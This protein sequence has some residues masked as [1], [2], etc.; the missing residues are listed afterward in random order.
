MRPMTPNS[1]VCL[2]FTA[3][4]LKADAGEECPLLFRALVTLEFS[5]RVIKDPFDAD[6]IGW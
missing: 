1:L 3:R 6:G 4:T 5:L 2:V